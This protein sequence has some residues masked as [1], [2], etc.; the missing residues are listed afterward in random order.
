MVSGIVA[1]FRRTLLLVCA[2][3][4]C[5]ALWLAHDVPFQPARALQVDALGAFF[6]CAS[7]LAS[8]LWFFSSANWPGF[9]FWLLLLLAA[10]AYSL[11]FIPGILL[12]Y[13]LLAV[14][15]LPGDDVELAPGWR[16]GLARGAVVALW[17]VAAVCLALGYGAIALRGSLFYDDRVAGALVDGFVF[18]FVLLAAVVPLSRVGSTRSTSLLVWFWR[19]VWLY[20]LV[21][22]YSLSPWNVGWGYAA[23]LLGGAAAIWS[24]ATALVEPRRS[25]RHDLLLQGYAALA[26]AGFGMGTSAGVAAG[27]YAVLVHQLLA[28]AFA[29]SAHSVSPA[30]FDH[31]LGWML[32]AAL[33][34]TAP[35]VAIWM[36]V[37]AA[38]A[39]GS[40]AL[41]GVLWLVGLLHALVA[42]LA[43]ARPATAAE[44]VAALVSG[45]MAV[46]APLVLLA[47]IDPVVRRL[48]GGLTPYGDVAIWPW[49]GLATRNAGAAQVLVFPSLAVAAL[50]VVLL[51]IVHLICRL[52]Q[53]GAATGESGEPALPLPLQSIAAILRAEVP[54]L[55][56]RAS[57][58]GGEP[59]RD[60]R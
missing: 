33:P 10:A 46:A 18:W 4:A 25:R 15:S 43:P 11:T 49:V 2:A 57:G 34:F 20:P 50:M 39:A 51:A 3:G 55:G 44:R 26:L 53:A 17:A 35:F 56:G 45:A 28:V 48:Q 31:Y 7:L 37:G 60:D 13:V 38:I 29:R 27:C 21:R 1:I 12:V 22:L 9:R 24:V 23:M 36:L 14:V 19:I 32:S 16:A 5:G 42:L 54:W 40:T 58:P 6:F 47:V 30:W 52:R 59:D 8:V 41:A